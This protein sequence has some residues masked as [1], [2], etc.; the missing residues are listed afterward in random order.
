MKLKRLFP[1][2]V[3]KEDIAQV[4]IGIKGGSD[5]IESIVLFLRTIAPLDEGQGP[6]A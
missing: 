5:V 3:Y 2:A 6:P 1:G 4:Q